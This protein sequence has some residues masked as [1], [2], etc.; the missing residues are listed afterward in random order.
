MI[1]S[2]KQ[3]ENRFARQHLSN[4]GTRTYKGLS[5]HLYVVSP[6]LKYTLRRRTFSDCHKHLCITIPTID[7]TTY[8]HR[9]IHRV[10]QRQETGQCSYR[11]LGELIAR[12]RRSGTPT[13]RAT[14]PTEDFND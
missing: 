3:T 13:S 10:H 9:G 11:A 6:S 12:P 1:M 7:H 4:M 2:F 5:A 8:V 14:G